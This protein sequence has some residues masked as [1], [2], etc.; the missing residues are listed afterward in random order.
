MVLGITW[1]G[2]ETVPEVRS[3]LICSLCVSDASRSRRVLL[4]LTARETFSAY[5]TVQSTRFI[6][7]IPIH[8]R[9]TN[10]FFVR[11]VYHARAQV[12]RLALLGN[13]RSWCLGRSIRLRFRQSPQFSTRL[14][15]LRTRFHIGSYR[16]PVHRHQ[17]CQLCLAFRHPRDDYKTEPHKTRALRSGR[18]SHEAHPTGALLHRYPNP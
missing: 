1:E 4:V 2:A 7:F 17:R 16:Y 11:C 3:V 9:T 8:I 18:N 15:V 5:G 6:W 10:G 13:G 12:L 14:L